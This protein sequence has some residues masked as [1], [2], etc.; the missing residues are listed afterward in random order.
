MWMFDAV[1]NNGV[2]T[3]W[4]ALAQLLGMFGLLGGVFYLSYLYDAPS[5]N[6]AVSEHHVVDVPGVGVPV[7]GVPVVDVPGVGVPVVGVPVVDVP[8][9]GVPGVGVP[10]VGVPVVDVLLLDV[11]CPSHQCTV[12][13]SFVVCLPQELVYSISTLHCSSCYSDNV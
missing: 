12:P 3:R 7:V 9:V 1:E 10:V 6:P 8:G 2:F 5:R 13:G 11:Q 4:Q